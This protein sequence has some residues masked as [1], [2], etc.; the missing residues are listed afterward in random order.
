ML[1]AHCAM[2]PLDSTLVQVQAARGSSI[3]VA[4]TRLGSSRGLRAFW[5][6]ASPML[7]S[8]PVQNALLFAGYGAGLGWCTHGKEITKCPPLWHVF[9]GGCLGGFIQSFI[10]SPVELVKVR[11]QLAEAG[12]T[13]V[14]Q[15][16]SQS[17][18]LVIN[19]AH[20]VGLRV[21]LSRGL[22]ATLGRDVFPHG[23]WF[24]SYEWC[25]R[26][27]SE[28]EGV[29]ASDNGALSVSSQ[30]AAG[31]IAATV[32]WAVGYP[33]DVIK[34]RVQSVPNK[35]G[36]RSVRDTAKQMLHQEGAGVF[37]RGFSLKLARAIPMSMI[38]FLVYEAT[39]RELRSLLVSS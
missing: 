11:L 30:L 37:F 9:A 3:P 22:G 17:C 14:V 2:K 34:T 24:T 12:A 25:K 4:I 39:A 36:V 1:H 23:V 18:A 19:T 13:T 26:K 10:M 35:S 32:A 27:L 29:C 6:G 21:L 16:T 38:G 7:W 31:G 8:V 33:F 28:W 15:G 5:S 20:A